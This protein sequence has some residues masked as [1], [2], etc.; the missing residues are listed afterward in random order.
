MF[1]IIVGGINSCETRSRY[2]KVER[3][4]SPAFHDQVIR[5]PQPLNIYLL[6]V[7]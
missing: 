2:G 1:G 5:K 7:V 3:K 4:V 6:L